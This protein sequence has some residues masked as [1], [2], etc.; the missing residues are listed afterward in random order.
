MSVDRLEAPALLVVD[1]QNDFV[2]E[3]AP[4]EV[5][6]ARETIPV[7]QELLRFFRGADRP[8]IF[9]RYLAGP[10]ETLIWKWSPQLKPDTKLCWPGHKRR[11]GDTEEALDCYDVVQELY[12]ENGEYVVDKYGYSSFHNSRLD[13]ILEAEH[14]K[15]LVVV[16]TVTQICVEDTVRHGMHLGYRMNLVSDAVSSF[17]PELHEATLRNVAMKY[18]WV[19]T[20]SEIL[21]DLESRWS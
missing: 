8:V 20:V 9:V 17:A 1:M 15:S 10:K 5:P 4:M 13:S 16:G 21:A 2:R 18:G 7:I 14:V 11:Y 19:S 6:Q 12:P 3:G